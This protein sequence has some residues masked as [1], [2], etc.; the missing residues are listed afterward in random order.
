MLVSRFPR[1][2]CVLVDAPIDDASFRIEEPSPFVEIFNHVADVN[3]QHAASRIT[4][5]AVQVF[6]SYKR[7]IN[8]TSVCK[9]SARE[10]YIFRV[11]EKTF[12]KHPGFF[13]FRAAKKH[14]AA[15]NIG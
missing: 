1:S 3:A 8:H 11:H 4:L 15:L 12:V 7:I 2:E 6:C 5:T 14:E 9:Q 13:E 10:I